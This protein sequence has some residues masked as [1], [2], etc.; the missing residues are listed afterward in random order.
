MKKRATSQRRWRIGELADA[1]GLT[2]RTL[3]HYEHLRLLAPAARTEGRQRLYDENDVRRLYLIRALRDL[4]L[5]LADIGR[6][7]DDDRAALANTLRAHRARVDAEIERLERLRTLL[8]HACAHADRDAEPDDVLATIEA[9][10]RVVRRGEARQKKGKAPADAEA[11][12]RELGDALR[13]CMEAGEAP[14]APRPRALAREALARIVEFAGG[15]RATLEAL[16]HLRRHTPPKNL[17]GW[18]PA[19]MH[20]LDQALASLPKTEHEPC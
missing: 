11:R 6:M 9:M 17:A 4:G 5:S 18:N 12:W 16:A 10:S 7:L 1:T 2:V 15:D 19:L 8:D 20:Y 13:A 14:S 3:H